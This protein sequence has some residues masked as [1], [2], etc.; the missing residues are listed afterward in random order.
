MRMS[1]SEP[2]RGDQHPLRL[3]VP[4]EEWSWE[5]PFDSGVYLQRMAV[6]TREQAPHQQDDEPDAMLN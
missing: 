4:V 6:P 3:F 1:E 5:M 2:G